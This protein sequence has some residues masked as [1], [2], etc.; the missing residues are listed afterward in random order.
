[1]SVP[2]SAERPA[3]RRRRRVR[4]LILEAAERVFAAEG[5]DGLSLRR[6][7]DE[8]DYSP[9]AIYKYFGSKEELVDALKEA[10]FERL[11]TR[12]DPAE[13]EGLPFA[14]RCR[15]NFVQ[16]IEAAIDRPYHYASAFFSVGDRLPGNPARTMCSAQFGASQKGKA[17]LVVVDLVREGQ[18]LGVFSAAFTP[19]MAAKSLWASLHGIAALLIHLPDIEGMRAPDDPA[20]DR[21]DMIAFH[22]DLLYRSLCAGL[23]PSPDGVTR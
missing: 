5:S 7:A 16:Y 20:R 4:G 21:A 1:M 9:G 6:L 13:F 11:L 22:C 19:W 14:E 10:F 3:E 18:A 17:F 23:P 2:V 12:L 15:L 8:I